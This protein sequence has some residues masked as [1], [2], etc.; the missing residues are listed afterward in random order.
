MK[1]ILVGSKFISSEL[2]PEEPIVVV[3][4]NIL[5]NINANDFIFGQGLYNKN[6]VPA[7]HFNN[8]IPERKGLVH[9]KLHHNVV[10]TKSQQ[11]KEK[12][13]CKGIIYDDNK[14]IGDHVTGWHISGMLQKELV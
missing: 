8:L 12:V 9:K 6:T 4:N 1:K 7:Q 2:M 5:N 3:S 13:Y 11:D 10:V 14:F